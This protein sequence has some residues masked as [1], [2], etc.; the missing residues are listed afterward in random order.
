MKQH[1]RTNAF[2]R[3]ESGFAPTKLRSSSDLQLGSAVSKNPAAEG[4]H[5]ISHIHISIEYFIIQET[6][7][8]YFFSSVQVI[9]HIASHCHRFHYRQIQNEH[10]SNE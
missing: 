3:V 5:E 7:M 9:M 2:K 6:V 10:R 4:F 1:A 8:S